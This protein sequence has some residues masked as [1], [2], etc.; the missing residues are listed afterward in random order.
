MVSGFRGAGCVIRVACQNQIVLNHCFFP[1]TR[2]SQLVSPTPH[3]VTRNPKS[4]TRK[5]ILDQ[6]K[7]RLLHLAAVGFA[8]KKQQYE[9]KQGPADH[10]AEP[11]LIGSNA[12]YPDPIG[13]VATPETVQ[14]KADGWLQQGHPEYDPHVADTGDRTRQL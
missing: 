10:Q 11:R 6:E 9:C 3:P 2:N 8:G 7:I 14:H 12:I 5:A 13:Y 4:L 1:T